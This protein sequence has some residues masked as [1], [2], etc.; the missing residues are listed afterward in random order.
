M[1]QY[2]AG[3][4]L[5]L[6]EDYNPVDPRSTHDWQPPELP[7]LDG[8]HD[9][10]LDCETT[11]L[12][13]WEQ[14]RPVGL[15]L[16]LPDGRTFYLPWGHLGGGNLPE[17]RVKEWAQRELRG[18]RI[19]NTNTRFDVHHLYQWGVDLEEQGNEVSD[20]S[21]YAAL[22]DDSRRVFNLEKLGQDFVG[23]GK[24]AT[25][26]DATKMKQYHAG[27]VAEYAMQDVR[28]VKK[29]R[30]VM[31]PQLTEQDLH[32]VRALEDRLIYVVC[33]M[34]RNGAPIDMELLEKWLPE[35]EQAY[36]RCIYDIHRECGLRVNPDSSEDL[37][38]LFHH[39]KLPFEAKTAS[40]KPS[41]T[42]AVMK[43][44]DH[45]VIKL[46]RRAGKL[47]D[48]RSKYLVKIKKSV[49]SNGILRYA[50]HQLRAD[51][52]G[53]N[54]GRFSSSELVPGVGVNI[55]QQLAVEKQVDAYGDDFI[56]RKLFIDN[57]YLS[58]DAAQIEY[59]IFAHY[60][61]NPRV[62]KAYQENPEMS[63]HKFVW[64]VVKEIKPDILYKPLKNL[65]FA[66]M[67]GAGLVK[68]AFMLEFISPD[69][70][71]DL[72]SRRGPALWN[73][74][75]L[76]ATKELR[77]NY[78]QMFPQVK[79]LL[80]YAS[81]T[82]ET[83]GYVHTMEGRRARFPTKQRL[84]SALNAV[85]QGTAADILKTKLVELHDARKETGFLLRHTEHDEVCGRTAGLETTAKVKQ[86]LN[87]QSFDL[88]VPILWEVGVGSNWAEA[89]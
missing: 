35:S 10:E 20:V 82:A 62:I 5:S 3:E 30:E 59:R 60:A 50:L 39:L 81:K 54:R 57:Q 16:G 27:Q 37:V 66:Y 56:V 26:I 19:T 31:W 1:Y 72:S 18:K 32:R 65:N 45:P 77:N 33:E 29:L 68:M 74:P 78:D 87:R 4:L 76:T 61:N 53:T 34:E 85:I 80:E 23:E 63:Y 52:G 79:K 64:D 8:I 6:M 22:L 49:C 24:H 46:V 67:Y 58:A 83:R 42:D 28:L 38:K 86:I 55:Q 89:K 40:G 47:A 9:I 21:H 13:W 43:K 12:R 73:A 11:G 70:F 41:F 17:E 48:L 36:H 69:Q 88:R 7:S 44:I 71:E 75:E 25:G 15:A 84:H 2:M 51:E 14:D